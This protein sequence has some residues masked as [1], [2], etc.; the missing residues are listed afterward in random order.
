[1]QMVHGALRASLTVVGLVLGC[2]PASPAP[3]PGAAPNTPDAAI[4]LLGYLVENLGY[5]QIT[6][7]WRVRAVWESVAA[8]RP[9]VRWSDA[10]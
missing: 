10:G 4:E 8:G 6:V 2:A 9:G 5:R 1:V 7:W 3:R